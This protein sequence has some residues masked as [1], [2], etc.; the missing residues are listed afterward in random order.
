MAALQP[1]KPPSSAGGIRAWYSL[2]DT[3]NKMP[4]LAVLWAAFSFPAHGHDQ[5]STW[6]IPGTA[7]SC[8]DDR[9]CYATESKNVGGTWYA[10]RR[11]DK[12]WLAVPPEAILTDGA[13]PDGNAHLCAP[14]PL[15]EDDNRVYC[16]RPA[17]TGG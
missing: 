15:T 17:Y 3:L 13:T 10:L 8:C 12:R 16:F 11:E 4:W 14:A 5:Y 9:D 6:K 2:G 1:C 7:R